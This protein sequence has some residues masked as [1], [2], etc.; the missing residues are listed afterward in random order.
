MQ[1]MHTNLYV[2]YETAER[3]VDCMTLS[4]R[5]KKWSLSLVIRNSVTSVLR[6]QM[7]QLWNYSTRDAAGPQHVEESNI[8]QP[9]GFR[10]VHRY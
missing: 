2:R 3:S 1:N 7:V 9:K 10:A 8:L 4:Q 6:R 5:T